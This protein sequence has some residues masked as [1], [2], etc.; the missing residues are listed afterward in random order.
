MKTITLAILLLLA[1][2]VL[3]SPTGD[4]YVYEHQAGLFV[5][6]VVPEG[7]TEGI[8]RL[9]ADIGWAVCDEN[10]CTLGDAELTIE[11]RQFAPRP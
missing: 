6:V 4:M 9:T 2:A 7:L 3:A 1:P 8:L 10:R 11:V 5:P